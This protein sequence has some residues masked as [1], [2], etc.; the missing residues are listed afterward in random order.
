MEFMRLH[1]VGCAVASIE[2]ALPF[3]RPFC[4]EISPVYRVTSQAVAVCFV[5]QGNGTYIELIEPL[6][7]N[8]N[9]M[10]RNLVRK[11]FTYYHLGYKVPDLDQAIA[12]LV[13]AEYRPQEPFHS[14]AFEGKRCCFLTSPVMHMIELI[15]E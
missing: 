6:E 15:E 14:E 13:E 8:S 3:Y 12:R 4:S 11:G 5:G 1:H 7:P 10:V 9:S 2:A